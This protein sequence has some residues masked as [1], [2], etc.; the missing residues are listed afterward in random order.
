MSAVNESG[1]WMAGVR[2]YAQ[3]YWPYERLLPAPPANAECWFFNQS[4]SNTAPRFGGFLAANTWGVI[5]ESSTRPGTS[6][7]RA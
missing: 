2:R 1:N 7:V 4:V 3:K 6:G 5:N